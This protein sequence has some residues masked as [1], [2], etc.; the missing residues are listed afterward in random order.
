MCHARAAV[1]R[2]QR[3]RPASH[4]AGL[5]RRRD[6]LTTLT[7]PQRGIESLEGIEQLHGLEILDLAD[8]AIVRIGPLAILTPVG[9]LCSLSL[10]GP[11]AGPISSVLNPL[12][13]AAA[14][15]DQCWTYSHC[16]EVGE[17]C[18]S[19]QYPTFGEENVP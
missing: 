17:Y 5:R 6:S 13:P 8:N 11:S 9:V 7:A 15:A 1:L 10:G 4:G 14:H 18:T 19:F 12:L 3:R 16:D 2:G